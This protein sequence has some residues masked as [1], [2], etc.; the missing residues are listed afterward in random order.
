MDDDPFRPAGI[1]DFWWT[2]ICVT[3]FTLVW[4]SLMIMLAAEV[5]EKPRRWLD[6]LA[7]GAKVIAYS[8]I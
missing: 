5:V 2:I 7:T 6:W 4:V 3:P 8:I 1:G